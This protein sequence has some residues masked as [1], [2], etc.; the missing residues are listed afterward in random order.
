MQTFL[1]YTKSVVTPQGKVN[2]ELGREE[3]SSDL[4]SME[5]LRDYI[6]NKE[7]KLFKV[8]EKI[9]DLRGE[10]LRILVREV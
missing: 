2:Q 5:G 8:V 7:G 4:S 3:V 1:V 6:V 10:E 9:A